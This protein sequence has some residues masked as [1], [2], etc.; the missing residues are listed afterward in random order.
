MPCFGNNSG[1]I[2]PFTKRLCEGFKKI[3]N[4]NVSHTIQLSKK[5]IKICSWIY[6]WC[7]TVCII[8]RYYCLNRDV[9]GENAFIPELC[10]TLRALFAWRGT[11]NICIFVLFGKWR[12]FKRIKTRQITHFWICHMPTDHLALLVKILN[13]L[14]ERKSVCILCGGARDFNILE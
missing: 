13:S 9:I 3:K 10:L 2:M 6:L 14:F 11:F 12:C 4:K 8:R 1:G 5:E 7:D